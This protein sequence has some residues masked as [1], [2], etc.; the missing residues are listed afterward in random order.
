[1]VET[2]EMTPTLHDESGTPPPYQ[3]SGLSALAT[4]QLDCRVETNVDSRKTS[5]NCM[6]QG[7]P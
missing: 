2:P 7:L 5:F 4:L 1:M 6:Q 3:E